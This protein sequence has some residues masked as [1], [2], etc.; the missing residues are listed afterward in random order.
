MLFPHVSTCFHRQRPLNCFLRSLVQLLWKVANLPPRRRRICFAHWSYL[1]IRCAA[2][3]WKLARGHWRSVLHGWCK[4]IYVRQAAGRGGQG[5]WTCFCCC[6]F[7]SFAL[8]ISDRIDL[9]SWQVAVN[10]LGLQP[11]RPLGAAELAWRIG[12]GWVWPG[13]AILI[14][15]NHWHA[16]GFERRLDPNFDRRFPSQFDH[17]KATATDENAHVE[18][19]V[20]GDHGRTFACAF[21]HH[22]F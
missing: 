13:L 19:N 15:E 10:L 14:Y 3:R 7:F 18:T 5:F 6:P 21:R 4:F 22:N 2:R 1:E 11:L 12:F 8:S 9:H 20:S 17:A 16:G